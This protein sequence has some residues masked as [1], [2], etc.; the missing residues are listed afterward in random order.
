[1]SRI[2]K[3]QEKAL[4][5]LKMILVCDKSVINIIVIEYL[6]NILCLKCQKLPALDNQYYCSDKCANNYDLLSE[7]NDILS[8]ISRKIAIIGGGKPED[9]D[10]SDAHVHDLIYPFLFGGCYCGSSE[11]CVYSNSPTL[12]QGKFCNGCAD[13]H[14]DGKE[15]NKWCSCTSL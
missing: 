12:Q 7:M 8:N 10:E 2:T 1:M 3:F 5:E 13:I 6:P 15:K 9:E 4:Y 11:V 14:D